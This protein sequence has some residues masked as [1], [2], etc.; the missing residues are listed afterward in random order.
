MRLISVILGASSTSVRNR[1][2]RRLLSWGFNNFSRVPIVKTGE[3][4]GKVVLDWGIEPEVRVLA[5]DTVVAV[6]TS[7][8]GGTDR[9]PSRAARGIDSTGRCRRRTGQAEGLAGR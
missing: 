8:T 7:R 2:T 1:E 3:L 5:Q 9:P 4:M 6:L